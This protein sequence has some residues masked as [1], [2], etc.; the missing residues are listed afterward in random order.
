MGVNRKKIQG[1]PIG[2]W[3]SIEFS[4]PWTELTNPSLDDLNKMMHALKKKTEKESRKPRYIEFSFPSIAAY[5]EFQKA[6]AKY[7]RAK[8]PLSIDKKEKRRR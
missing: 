3:P 1:R 8:K 6:L 5:E 7:W 2:E 4:R